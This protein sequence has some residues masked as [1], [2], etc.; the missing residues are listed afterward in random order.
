M[1]TYAVEKF[2]DVYGEMLP[3]LHEHYGEISLHKA[4]DVPLDPQLAAY[5][6][7]ERDGS[8]MTVVGREDGEIVAYFLCFIAPGLHYQSCLTCSPDIFFVRPDK[9][10]GMVGVRLFKFVEKELKRR[11]VKLWFVG[12]KNAHDATALFRFLK[13]EPVETTYSKWLED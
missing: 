5:H 3:L 7:R 12:S 2:S 9:R 8:L 1:I 10:T 13:F 6:A 4:H 11:G